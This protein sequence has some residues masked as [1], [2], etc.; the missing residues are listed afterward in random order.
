MVAIA[1]PTLPRNYTKHRP[2][3]YMTANARASLT[4]LEMAWIAE[5]WANFK[6]GPEDEP[7]NVIMEVITPNEIR[8]W[9]CDRSKEEEPI[10]MLPEDY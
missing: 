8:V 2:I 9:V 7:Y 10:L 6:G 1:K 4:V 3:A 5:E